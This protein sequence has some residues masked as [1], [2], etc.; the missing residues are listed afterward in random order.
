MLISFY[1]GLIIFLNASYRRFLM[2]TYSYDVFGNDQIPVRGGNDKAAQLQPAQRVSNDSAPKQ[3]S[4]YYSYE[5]GQVRRKHN[6]PVLP[7]GT[8]RCKDYF[9]D[10][11]LSWAGKERH[12]YFRMSFANWDDP[13]GWNQD[14]WRLY[15]L[16]FP[17]MQK[18]GAGASHEAHMFWDEDCHEHF[19]CWDQPIAEFQDAN[20]IAYT[21]AKNYVK[22][23]LGTEQNRNRVKLPS[24]TF[25]GARKNRKGRFSAG[26]SFLHSS[27][28]ESS[29]HSNARRSDSRTSLFADDSYFDYEDDRFVPCSNRTL[30]MTREVY[31]SI[32]ECI[33]SHLAERGGMLGSTDGE[34]I[35]VFEFDK[36]AVTNGAAYSPDVKHLNGV[37]DDWQDT[38]IRFMGFVHSHPAYCKSPSGADEEYAGRIMDAF[39][40]VDFFVPIVMTEPDYGRF[41]IFPYIA[42]RTSG[43][44]VIVSKCGFEKVKA[45]ERANAGTGIDIVEVSMFDN[46]E[47]KE[48]GMD[49]DANIDMFSGSLSEEEIEKRFANQDKSLFDKQKSESVESQDKDSGSGDELSDTPFDRVDGELDLSLLK[50][51]QVIGIGCGGARDFYVDMARCGAG[52][53]LL[54]DGDRVTASNLSSQNA[55]SGEIGTF[56]VESVAA[57]IRQVNPEAIVKAVPEYLTDVFCD[58]WFESMIASFGER[59]SVVLCAFTDCFAAQARCFRLAMKYKLPMVSAQ[60]YAK[61]YASEVIYHLPGRTPTSARAFLVDRYDNY[62]NKGFSNPVT[63]KGSPIFNTT[64]LNA[65]CEKIAI[66]LLMSYAGVGGAYTSFIDE[67][68]DRNL[69]LIKQHPL[70][71][72]IP[73]LDEFLGFAPERLF[74]DCVWL[75]AEDMKL[76]AEPS[77][78]DA[79]YADAALGEGPDTRCLA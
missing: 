35:D 41:K 64:R 9:K 3:P 79:D 21:W 1:L 40:M 13:N 48:E 38:G 7:S 74:D 11:R 24:G 73:G 19:V 31:D 65:L 8:F 47:A 4:H 28:K 16:T 54:M 78:D 37:L 29:V 56:K 39:D 61:G 36:Y 55:Y 51:A 34:T 32:G 59:K 76:S 62:L 26:R 22:N 25:R 58:G 75:S 63:S 27:K 12:F 6:R 15:I 20:A 50:D 72:R 77:K 23:C 71:I 18:F 52:R 57:M 2:A 10:I 43:E 66:G 42:E 44:G 45:A 69:I 70:A 5:N 30:K 53:F 46:C 68:P 14:S 60:H 33:G 67:F 17:N 49:M